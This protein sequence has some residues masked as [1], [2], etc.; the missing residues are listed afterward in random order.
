MIIFSFSVVGFGLMVSS[1]ANTQQ[2]A[3]LGTF[4]MR[5]PAIALSGFAAPLENMPEWLQQAVWINPM[6]HGVIIFRGLFLK[7]MPA[8]LVAANAWP[9][10]VIGGVSLAL[11]GWMF[12]RRMG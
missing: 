9:L 7:D 2:Q 4:M 8:S 12:R 3:I 5:V 6:K 1:I 11:A 10:L